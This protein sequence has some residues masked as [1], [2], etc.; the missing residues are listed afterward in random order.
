MV[1]RSVTNAKRLLS[2][3]LVLVAI[4]TLALPAQASEY[5]PPITSKLDATPTVEINPDANHHSDGDSHA[6]IPVPLSFQELAPSSCVGGFS[7]EYPCQR[8]V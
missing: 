6:N 5:N 7:G 4:F 3:I 8:A 1:N 2:L